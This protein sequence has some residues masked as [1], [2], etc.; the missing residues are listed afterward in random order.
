MSLTNLSVKFEQSAP[1]ASYATNGFAFTWGA[2]T[3]NQIVMVISI[4]LAVSTFAVNLYFQKRRD[5]REKDLHEY[6]MA[7]I[8]PSLRAD[9]PPK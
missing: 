8:H 7:Y 3:F 5:K 1:A 4:V 2:L 6:Q 9:N